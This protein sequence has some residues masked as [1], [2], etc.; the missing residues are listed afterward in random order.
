MFENPP[1]FIDLA[2]WILPLLTA[3]SWREAIKTHACHYRGDTIAKMIGLGSF[4][5]TKNLDAFGSAL[6]PILLIIRNKGFVYGWAQSI[7]IRENFLNKGKFD[8]A[9]IIIIA[10]LSNFVMAAGWA[11]I[12]K[13]GL[14]LKATAPNV[15][16]FLVQMGKNGIE[17]NL[18]LIIA[19]LTPLPPMDSSYLVRSLLP[20][21][22]KMMYVNLDYVGQY[23]LF[24]VVF[25]KVAHA[26][27]AIAMSYL[28]DL[29]F[30]LIGFSI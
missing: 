7:E 24:T 2:C 4:S 28:Q 30:G 17:I 21:T 18:M 13:L 8:V 26:E 9:L 29:L 3:V 16:F 5:L 12:G 22:L 11:F 14:I 27:I 6:A 20:Q 10:L 1:W 19:H 25:M 23:L 15:A